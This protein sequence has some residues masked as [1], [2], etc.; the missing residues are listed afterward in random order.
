MPGRSDQFSFD[1]PPDK[2]AAAA[3][4]EEAA[5]PRAAAGHAPYGSPRLKP[6]SAKGLC[7]R[8]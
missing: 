1:F 6:C 5:T 8:R 3:E 4:F 7:L 2:A